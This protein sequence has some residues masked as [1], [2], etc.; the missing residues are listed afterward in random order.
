VT[1]ILLGCK[2]CYQNTKKGE[3]IPIDGIWGATCRW[4]NFELNYEP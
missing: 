1:D 4:Y 2:N 3:E